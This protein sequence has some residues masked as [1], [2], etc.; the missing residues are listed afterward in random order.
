VNQ[1]NIFSVLIF[2]VDTQVVSATAG[3]LAATATLALGEARFQASAITPLHTHPAFLLQ[4]RTA[5]YLHAILLPFSIWYDAGA[6]IL[7][8]RVVGWRQQ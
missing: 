2:S 6:I 7:F 4:F 5:D 3:A 1:C 8:C